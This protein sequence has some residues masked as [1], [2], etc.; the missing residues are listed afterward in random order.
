[1]KRLLT[2]IALAGVISTPSLAGDVPSGGTPSPPPQGMTQTTN[3]TLPGDIAC[4]FTGQI[5][6]AGLSGLLAVLSLLAT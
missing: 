2:A 1:M 3:E 6:E 5:S 4:D